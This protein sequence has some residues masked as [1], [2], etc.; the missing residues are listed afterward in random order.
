M[1]NELDRIEEMFFLCQQLLKAILLWQV[2]Q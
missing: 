1:S 2:L